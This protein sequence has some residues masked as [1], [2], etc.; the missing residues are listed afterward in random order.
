M[1]KTLR[2]I[3][4]LM[5]AFLMCVPCIAS[6]AIAE[7]ELTDEV[8]YVDAKGKKAGDGS[9]EKPFTDIEDAKK[10]V[11]KIRDAG[12]SKKVTV[13]LRGGH[14][15][16]D[17]TLSFTGQDSGSENF[18]IVYSA[19]PGEEVILTMAESINGSRFQK[20]T[21]KNVLAKIDKSVHDKVVQINL[22]DQGI[23]SVGTMTEDGAFQDDENSCPIL[24]VDGKMQTLARWPNSGWAYQGKFVRYNN[25]GGAFCYTENMGD[26]WKDA[27]DAWYHGFPYYLWSDTAAPI[28]FE[29]EKKQINLNKYFAYGILEGNPYYIKNLIE[30]LDAPGEWFVDRA[31]G[32]LYIYPRLPDVAK[33]DFQYVAKTDTIVEFNGASYITLDGLIIEGTRGLGMEIKNY[34]HHNLITNS[35]FRNLG[36]KAI[37]MNSG[38][39]NNGITWCHLHDL[40]KTGINISE[41]TAD[42]TTLEHTKNYVENCHI[43]NYGITS[44]CYCAGIRVYGVGNRIAN[45]RIHGADHV[46]IYLNGNDNIIE[47]NELYDLVK[48]AED[49]AAIYCWSDYTNLGHIIRYNSLHEIYGPTDGPPRTHTAHAIYFDDSASF[50]TFY[51]NTFANMEAGIYSN[52]GAYHNLQN[53]LF[54]NVDKFAMNIWNW[55]SAS[56][57]NTLDANQ[58]LMD[59]IARGDAEWPTHGQYNHKYRELYWEE[60]YPSGKAAYDAKYP[61]LAT[62]LQD[63]P[64]LPKNVTIK[65]NVSVNGGM[66]TYGK[67]FRS[68]GLVNKMGDVGENYNLTSEQGPVVDVN[69]GVY[70]LSDYT[71]VHEVIPGFE[72]LDVTK[73]GPE[74]VKNL[75]V[76][77]FNTITPLIE[78]KELDGTSVTFTW[79]DSSGADSYRL[80]IATDREFKNLV[81]D[82]TVR[83][84]YET[85]KNLRFNRQKYYWKV[86]AISSSHAYTGTKWNVNGV[87]TFRTSTSSI[88]SYYKYDIALDSA[89]NRLENAVEGSEGGQF[90]PGSKAEFQTKINAIV[91]T[92]KGKVSQKDVDKATND[93]EVAHEA[94]LLNQQSEILDI[95]KLLEDQGAWAANRGDGVAFNFDDAGNL[96]VEETGG[97]AYKMVCYV[98]D[99]LENHQIAKLRAKF[100]FRSDST[101]EYVGINLRT[102]N[103]QSFVWPSNKAYSLVILRDYIELQY[104]DGGGHILE[105]AHTNKLADGKEHDLEFGALSVGEGVRLLFKI[106]G[107]VIFDYLDKTGFVPDI[108]YFSAFAWNIPFTIM[109]TQE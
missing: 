34:S 29:T 62:H 85:V 48:L 13:Y 44:I 68:S 67:D 93:I 99:K 16:L 22:Y 8:I 9:I 26:K 81:Y 72:E 20:V 15:N 39:N 55:C 5:L 6:V 24:V 88:P 49:M 56:D 50:G 31:T 108:G 69:Q 58:R 103:T 32:I 47:Y 109:K 43:E 7:E 82:Q 102:K 91:S 59:A 61:W 96:V 105:V 70:N 79:E 25:S 46:G 84:T 77:D 89:L 80:V 71:A 78:Q 23:S 95:G 87:Q 3:L 76:G 60:K 1:K 90:S 21:D 75:T 45:N 42:F 52:G 66:K 12:K 54:I 40:C 65:N 33:S 101:S 98:K 106:D 37:E 73:T 28:T 83:R 104:F 17:E 74:G 107:E 97:P 36:R 18:S 35:E 11:R 2:K 100:E 64:F 14:Y 92:I 10:E 86:E 38:S 57:T 51:G 27:K 63:D 41:T 19:Y 53:N 30:E 94:F 4:S